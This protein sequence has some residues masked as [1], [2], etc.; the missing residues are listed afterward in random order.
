MKLTKDQLKEKCANWYAELDASACLHYTPVS[1]SAENDEVLL[2][3]EDGVSFKFYHRQ[4][5]CESVTLKQGG[6][7]SK[8]LGSPIVFCQ[9]DTWSSETPPDAPISGDD[10]VGGSYTWTRL[11][12]QAQGQDTQVFWWLGT[13]N[14]YY[15]EGI[16]VRADF[17]D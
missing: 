11:T 16:D 4:D 12:I 17:E 6:D 9:M 2:R 10:Y 7:T 15:S 1:I 13:S 5:C 3:C 14:G 8:L